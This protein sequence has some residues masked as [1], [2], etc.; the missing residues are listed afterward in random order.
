VSLLL[1][2]VS[3]GISPTVNLNFTGENFRCLPFAARFF[4]FTVDRK[5]AAG[6]QFFDFRFVVFKFAGSNNLDISLT[7]TVIDFD[8]AE[9]RRVRTQPL[10]LA[11]VPIADS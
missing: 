4:D 2:R 1:Q 3:I 10:T 7:G 9:S 5:A 11:V 8:E 6:S